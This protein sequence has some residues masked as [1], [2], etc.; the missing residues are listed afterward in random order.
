MDPEKKKFV[1]SLIFPVA[2]VILIWIIKIA[3]WALGED[4]GFLGIYPLR[5]ENL[6][7]ILTGPLVHGDWGHL[8]ANTVPLLVLG[9]GLFYFYRPIA[10][11][12]F[13]LIYLV[14]GFWLWFGGRPGYHI[15]ASGIIYG[16]AAFLFLSGVLRKY[17]RLMA[18]SLLVVFLYGSLIWGIFPLDMRTS[19]EGH[20]YGAI[21]GLIIA[22]YYKNRGPQRKK[23]EWEIEEELEEKGENWDE[24]DWE[25]YYHYH[26]K[27][28]NED[29]E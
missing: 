23:Y 17:T 5:P 24:Y 16:L 14:S 29:K 7:G 25:I 1:Y 28:D 2:F 9:V 11:K 20:L 4:F 12:V 6:H 22:V 8:A 10:P 3:E 18:L 21:A 19:W 27:K 26:G 15:G 13:I